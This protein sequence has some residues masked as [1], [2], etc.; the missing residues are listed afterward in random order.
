MVVILEMLYNDCLCYVDQ[1]SMVNIKGG[2]LELFL[3][4]VV[5]NLPDMMHVLYLHGEDFTRKAL[6]GECASKLMI[7]IGEKHRMLDDIISQ[8]KKNEE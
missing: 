6:I 1:D 7:K 2:I 8:Y 4:A 5:S 3:W